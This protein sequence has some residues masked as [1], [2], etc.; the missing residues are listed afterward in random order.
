[1]LS[2]PAGR[3]RRRLGRRRASARR[4]EQRL[5]EILVATRSRWSPRGSP[6]GACRR[7]Q[8]R[9]RRAGSSA[10]GSRPSVY[11]CGRVSTSLTGRP[12]LRAAIAAS[13]DVRPAR[14]AVPKPPP[15][16]G[17]ITR[18]FSSGR[19]KLRDVAAARCLTPGSCRRGSVASPSQTAIVAC[20]SIGLWCSRGCGRSRRSGATRARRSVA[21]GSARAAAGSLITRR[22]AGR[23]A[24][25]RCRRLLVVVDAD[26]VGRVGACSRVS[27]TTTA[28]AGRV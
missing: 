12:D 8:R 19:P 24:S 25:S 5:G 9:A 3:R 7:A 11:I 26:Q 22:L 28:T 2:G 10:A 13:D 20:G 27:A 18:T 15:T 17:E 4:V 6:S 21:R 16:N 14:S 23:G 1:M